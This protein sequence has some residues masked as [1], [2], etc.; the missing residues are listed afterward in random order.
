VL[1]SNTYTQ[2]QLLTILGTPVG[3]DAS[4]MLAQQL[5]AAL[6]N[7]AN[8]TDRTPVDATITHANSLIGGSTIPEKIKPNL[9]L[10]KQMVSDAKILESYNQ[11]LLTQD[12][13]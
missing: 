5:I 3:G 2:Q 9:P 1:G 6:L 11:G 13:G 10:G 7:I 4:V 12:C 8:G